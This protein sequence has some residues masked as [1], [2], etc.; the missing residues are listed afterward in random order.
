M[1]FHAINMGLLA[2]SDFTHWV[3]VRL[4]KKPMNEG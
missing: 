3:R 2:I 4:A 1:Q